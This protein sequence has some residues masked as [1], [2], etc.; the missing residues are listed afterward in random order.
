MK[1]QEL[2]DQ[3]SEFNPAA[4]VACTWEGVIASI[5]VYQAADSVVLID[6]DNGDY[7]ITHQRI[8]CKTCGKPAWT[9]K[10]TVNGVLTPIEPICFWCWTQLE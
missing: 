7:K 6:G 1:V 9:D 10:L 4:E 5:E 8:S 2:I 3:L